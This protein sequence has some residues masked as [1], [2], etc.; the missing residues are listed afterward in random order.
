[1]RFDSLR[2]F[3]GIYQPLLNTR[4]EHCVARIVSLADKLCALR[5]KSLLDQINGH[6]ASVGKIY[7]GLVLDKAMVARSQNTGSIRVALARG[8]VDAHRFAGG[9]VDLSNNYPQVLGGLGVLGYE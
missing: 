5:L 2:S 4:K 6:F 7:Y 8:H 3:P 9:C 1:V